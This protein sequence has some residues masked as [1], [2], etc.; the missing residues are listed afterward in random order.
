VVIQ[1]GPGS[2][3]ILQTRT[4]QFEPLEIG[5]P[6]ADGVA[7][8]VVPA[9][10][11][12]IDPVLVTGIGTACVSLVEDGEGSIDC[13]GGS[14]AY[15]LSFFV[16]H[17]TTPGSNGNS[18]SAGGLPDDPECDDTFTF[19]DGSLSSACLEGTACDETNPPKHPGV[20]NSP[21]TMTTAGIFAGGGTQLIIKQ[22]ISVLTNGQPAQ[23]GPD[24]QPCTADDAPALVTESTSVLS[25]GYSQVLLYN[26]NSVAAVSSRI[27]PGS[28][29]LCTAAG[30]ACPAGEVCFE[31]P[32]PAGNTTQ[33]TCSASSAECR[34]RIRCGLKACTADIQGAVSSCASLA[35]GVATGTII[36]GGFVSLDLDPIGDSV[37]TVQFVAE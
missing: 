10:G 22:Q 33:P 6:A 15:D 5:A 23:L 20:C 12:H 2:Q 34:C 30:P 28:Q 31:E 36:G 27:G 11:T 29:M 19:P 8:I 13:D 35:G 21:T 26:A 3:A 25:T 4:A 14:P 32:V 24:G 18:G 16:D 7:A 37:V 9:N 17:N 1:L